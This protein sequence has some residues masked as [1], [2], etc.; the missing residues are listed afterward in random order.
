[1]A[2]M[3]RAAE[4]RPTEFYDGLASTYRHLYPDWQAACREQGR[5][6]QGLLR[7]R[8]GPGPHTILDAAVGVGTQLLG[9]ADF[10]HT[11]VGSDVS[12]RA[13]Q[14][15][16]QESAARSVDAAFAVADM[17][18]LPFADARFDAVVCADNAV[19]HLTS[20][21]R[22]TT[23]LVGMR[24]V[25]RPGGHLLVSTRDYEQAGGTR[26]SGTPPQVSG[27]GDAVVVSFQ[28]WDWRAD[29]R[30]YDLQHFQVACEG[31]DWTVTRRTSRLWA[32][33]RDEL[34]ECAEEA[35]LTKLEWLEPEASG[36]FQPLMVAQVL[37]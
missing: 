34:T 3:D 32:I 35:G 29:G 27:A 1:M 19:A 22:L 14:R 24:R 33:T 4:D 37:G 15:A 31:G 6:L 18:D 20:P 7:A 26:P 12:S 9:L 16:R 25:V 11:L 23:A 8:Q 28:V 2:G 10:G 36:F 30:R 21:S 13:I 17:R 5:A